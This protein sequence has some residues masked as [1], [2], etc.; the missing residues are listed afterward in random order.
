MALEEGT[1]HI[2]LTLECVFHGLK[3]YVKSK[4]EDTRI[5]MP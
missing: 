3:P 4:E 2:E 1:S 5:T